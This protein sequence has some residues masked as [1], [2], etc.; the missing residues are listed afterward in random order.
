MG[1]I[2]GDVSRFPDSPRLVR[3]LRPVTVSG[4][5]TRGDPHLAANVRRLG[6]GVPIRRATGAPARGPPNLDSPFSHG[7]VR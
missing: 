5:P 4:V 3:G 6:T 1:E 7:G 2:A